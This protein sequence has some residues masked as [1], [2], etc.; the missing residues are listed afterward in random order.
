[1]ADTK[2]FAFLS[3]VNSGFQHEDGRI[4]QFRERLADGVSMH[5]GHDMSI[6][7]DRHDS[8]RKQTWKER[9]AEAFA[10]DGSKAPA[11]LIAFVT[12][13]F[14]RSDHSKGEWRLSSSS[15]GG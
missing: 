3:F 10:E 15:N 12:P 11:P 1:V 4:A 8:L 14:F 2:P 5:T 13:G 7:Q 9:V 6:S